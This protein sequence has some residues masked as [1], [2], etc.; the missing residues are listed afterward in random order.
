MSFQVFN[1]MVFVYY[2][3]AVR[4]LKAKTPNFIEAVYFA[5]WLGE[6]LRELDL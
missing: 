3:F 1:W 4:Y 5:L 6:Q 2:S